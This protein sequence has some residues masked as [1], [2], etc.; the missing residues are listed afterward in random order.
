MLR[1]VFYKAMT[2]RYGIGPMRFLHFALTEPAGM[3]L[4]EGMIGR[5]REE[6]FANS[7]AVHTWL[8]RTVTAQDRLLY[9]PAHPAAWRRTSL[10]NP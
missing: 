4:I 8:V 9:L 6:I 5:P 2:M 10:A 1:R 3:T 7:L